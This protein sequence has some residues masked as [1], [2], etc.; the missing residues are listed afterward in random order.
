MATTRRLAMP[1]RV[2]Q[3]WDAIGHTSSAQNMDFEKLVTVVTNL[4]K[5]PRGE[6]QVN[7]GRS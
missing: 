6:S 7:K 4:H 3:I 1:I 5:V 2:H